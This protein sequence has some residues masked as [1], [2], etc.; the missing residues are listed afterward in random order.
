MHESTISR[1]TSNKYTHTPQGIYE[2]KYFF[3][4]AIPRKGCEA[5][6]S[7][8]IKTR[9]RKMIQDEDKANDNR[10]LHRPQ[11]DWEKADKRKQHGSVEQRLFDGL[12][13]M[14]AVRKSVSAFAD[15]NNRDL[16]DTG[17]EHLFTFIRNHFNQQYESVLVVGNF[18]DKPQTLNLSDLGNRGLFELG[19]LRDLATGES[20]ALFKD[21][22]VIPP[23]RYYWLTVQS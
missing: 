15:F 17:N 16:I 10:W 7:E 18:D 2:L 5:L 11:I 19:Q 20:P 14:I 9:I 12:Q 3:S 8:S 13:R 6:A 21:Q 1:V 22:L 4:T 23:Y